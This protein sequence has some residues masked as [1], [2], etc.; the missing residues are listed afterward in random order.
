MNPTNPV[1]VHPT[2][3]PSDAASETGGRPSFNGKAMAVNFLLTAIFDIGLAILTF[4]V[5]K[6][7]G[8]VDQVAYLAGGIGPLIML[9]IT[10]IRARAIS[11]ASVIV[12]ITLVL[13]AVAAFIA[14]TDSRL[15]LAKDSVITG[16]FGLA[17]LASLLFPRPLMFYFGAKFATDGT[18]AGL[19]YWGGLWQHPSFRRSQYTI[20]NLWGI[21]YLVEAALRVL[22]AYTVPNFQ[23]ASAISTVLPWAFLAGLIFFTIR[24][25][26]R[27]RDAAMA[28]TRAES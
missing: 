11:G 1:T 20:N 22:I 12:L 21:G 7:W 15:L 19:R 3:E 13:S 5:A 16:G 28:A 9:M 23:V 8:A 2:D 25:G 24:I 26:K 14:G 4:R 27:T 17:C 18:P 6:Q 10:W